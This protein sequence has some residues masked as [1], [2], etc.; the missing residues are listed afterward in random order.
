MR[1]VLHILLI[2]TSTACF[3]Q[4]IHFSQFNNMPLNLNPGIAG[5]TD[6]DYRVFSSYRNQWSTV[7]VPFST[8]YFAYDMSVYESENGNSLGA[9]V[10]FFNDK[11]GTSAMRLNNINLAVSYA[12]RVS[13]KAV[14]SSGISAAYNQRSVNISGLRWDNQ[15]DGTTVNTAI[16]SGEAGVAPYHYFDYAAGA[17]YKTRLQ[18]Q[19]ELQIGFSALHL[20]MPRY[21]FAGTGDRL[22]LRYNLSAIYEKQIADKA[23]I[24]PSMLLMKQGPAYEITAGAMYKVIIGMDSKY[25]GEN[26]SSYMMIGGFYRVGDAIVPSFY[27]DYKHIAALGISYDINLSGLSSATRSMGGPEISLI[28]KGFLNAVSARK[29]GSVRF[30]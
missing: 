5:F 29:K 28:Y 9:G 20:N 14:V 2:L 3:S 23:Y 13:K 19:N 25:T 22:S 30:N 15:Y 17:I 6:C 1:R 24:V 7:T 27:Y 11:A 10:S 21:S 18:R 12:F 4:D 26:T 16:A 8:K